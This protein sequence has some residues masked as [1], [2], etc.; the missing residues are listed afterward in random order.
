MAQVNSLKKVVG[1]F[2][3]ISK[4]P[5]TYEGKLYEPPAHLYISN[6]FFRGFKCPEKCGWCCPRFSLDYFKYNLEDFFKLYPKKAK[7]LEKQETKFNGKIYKYWS[8]TQKGRKENFCQFL[9]EPERRCSIHKANPFYCRVE[10]IKIFCVNNT[11][12]IMKKKFSRGWL[13]RRGTK[14]LCQFFPFD[15]KELKKD[16]DLFIE[17]KHIALEFGIETYCD[18]IISLLKDCLEIE[19]APDRRVRI[20]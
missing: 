15:M 13:E 5:F 4:K 17:L 2:Q 9:T 19:K 12:W 18:N 8:I 6:L 1:Y 7:L 14:A 11:G 10:P 16:I 20:K 3:V